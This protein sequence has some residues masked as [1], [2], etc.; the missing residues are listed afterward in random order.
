[1]TFEPVIATGNY[2]GI[3]RTYPGAVSISV[4]SPRWYGSPLKFKALAPFGFMRDPLRSYLPKY[5]ALLA[6]LDPREVLSEIKQLVYDKARSMGF[7]DAA[8]DQVTPVMLCYEKAGEFCH[9]RLVA[10][11]I[12]RE[13][14][15]Q[16]PEV[17]FD[18]KAWKGL[19][20]VD[21][22]QPV[23]LTAKQPEPTETQGALF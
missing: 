13:L 16:V 4:S 9:R 2:A 14:E 17:R 18:Q 11:W 22:P 23:H 10:E 21:N 8:A 3:P 5:E 12:E 7:D 19:Y 15:I 1:M 20:Q 6:E